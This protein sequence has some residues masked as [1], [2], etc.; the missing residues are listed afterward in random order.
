MSAPSPLRNSS[1]RWVV[2]DSSE[3]EAA[4]KILKSLEGDTTVDLLG[5]GNYGEQIADIL[6]PGTSTLHS[7]IRY[8]IFIPTL[9]YAISLSET[10]L[11]PGRQLFELEYELQ[12]ALI[13]NEPESVVGRNRGDKL[14]YWPSTTHWNSLNT[15]GFFGESYLSRS[16]ALRIL[17]TKNRAYLK[18]DEGVSEDYSPAQLPLLPE[19]ADIASG[20]TLIRKVHG[21]RQIKIREAVSFQLSKL[22]A[23][24]LYKQITH[25]HA[26]SLYS[27]IL[28]TTPYRKV[29]SIT[30]FNQIGTQGLQAHLKELI[31]MARKYSY[32]SQGATIAHR[33]ALCRFYSSDY[34]YAKN[35]ISYHEAS[36]ANW[37]SKIATLSDWSIG[38]LE[39]AMNS[40]QQGEKGDSKLSR[41]AKRFVEICQKGSA[42]NA[43]ESLVRERE[44]TVKFNRSHFRDKTR[45]LPKNVYE[46]RV[47]LQD[48][49]A[50]DFRW[51]IAKRNIE[52][53]LQ[54]L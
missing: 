19:F 53:I 40:V 32:F 47:E 45:L 54:A 41:F 31:S 46:I 50:F 36:F 14:K 34:E 9:L 7:R 3:L 4:R 23:N 1:I 6:F 29:R 8:Q 28:K 15:L 33:W 17:D 11:D 22:E 43:L 39:S 10:H 24:L 37:R 42:I 2:F 13:K 27:H 16:Q 25:L 21:K 49:F 52:D 18:N 5:L 35:A 51:R 38:R 44:D 20:I 30:D 26:S 48:L 12:R